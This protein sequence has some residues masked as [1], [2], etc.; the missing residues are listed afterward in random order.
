MTTIIR[1]T[2]L[3]SS[4]SA[5]RATTNKVTTAAVT[6]RT[7]ASGT[8]SGMN[9]AASASKL[10]GGNAYSTTGKRTS[11]TTTSSSDLANNIFIKSSTMPTKPSTDMGL[12]VVKNAVA[13]AKKKDIVDSNLKDVAMVKTL[14]EAVMK[15][16]TMSDAQTLIAIDSQIKDT[17]AEKAA[18]DTAQTIIQATLK[19]QNQTKDDVHAETQPEKTK[20]DATTDNREE[21]NKADFPKDENEQPIDSPVVEKQTANTSENSNKRLITMVCILLVGIAIMWYIHKQ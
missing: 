20:S 10:D 9:V 14:T 4:I 12:E 11:P 7:T 17:A 18:D 16:G 13:E 6:K 21:I 19:Q 1:K 2:T 3:P 8:P 15:T 5:G